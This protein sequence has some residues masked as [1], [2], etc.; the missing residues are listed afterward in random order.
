M[1]FPLFWL[2]PD[3]NLT[4]QKV[5][6]NY[7]KENEYKQAEWTEEREGKDA[8]AGRFLAV[9]AFLFGVLGVEYQNF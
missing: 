1:K 8:G 2:V 9:V 7:Y 4:S 5:Q 3:A 6:V